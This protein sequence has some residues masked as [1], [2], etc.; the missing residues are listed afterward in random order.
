MN[1]FQFVKLSKTV[2]PY[3]EPLNFNGDY[4][5]I[6]FGK[7]NDYDRYLI[8]LS[9]KSPLH[10]GILSRKRKMDVGGGLLYNKNNKFLE[11]FYTE[12]DKNFHNN[13][14]NSI[15][16]FG[17]S[18]VGVKW[19]KDKIISLEYIPFEYCRLSEPDENDKIP[20]VLISKNWKKSNND[21]RYKPLPIPTFTG[22]KQ[23]DYEIAIIFNETEGQYYP[24]SAYEAAIN[25]IESDYEI[26][27][28][29]LANIKNGFN[30]GAM[31]VFLEG[32][33]T[34]EEE[35]MIIEEIEAKKG[36]D[37]AGNFLVYFEKD[38]GR[39]PQITQLPVS[40]LDKQFSILNETIDSKIIVAHEIPRILSGIETPGSL[41]DSKQLLE[42]REQFHNDYIKYQQDLM[43]NFLTEVNDINGI[44]EKV[45]YIFPRTL[46]FAILDNYKDFLTRE[47]IREFLGLKPETTI[48]PTEPTETIE[49]NPTENV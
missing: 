8:D 43:I 17:G 38:Q 1:K 22:V 6:K 3:Q 35:E 46:N 7:G 34:P 23:D 41:G 19:F 36:A 31:I 14:F 15:E 5:Y 48:T 30:P 45:E 9:K 16:V 47:E 18:Y 2:E 39:A 13:V 24:K 25:Y 10:S 20:F 29:H 21:A 33:A 28:F 27:K 44:D 42:A 4:K 37:G 40:D 12:L 26:S 11:Q 32:D 49:N